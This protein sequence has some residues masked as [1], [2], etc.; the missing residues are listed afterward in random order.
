DKINRKGFFAIG[1]GTITFKQFVGVLKV[2]DLT[3]EVLP[4]IDF[5]TPDDN[6]TSIW[7]QFLIEMLQA[8]KKIE[9]KTSTLAAINLSKNTVLNLYINWF[10]Q[11]LEI[12]M[13]RGLVKKYQRISENKKSLSGKLEISKQITTN[14]IN[15]ERFYVTYN[16]YNRNNIYNAILYKCLRTIQDLGLGLA[17][18]ANVGNLLNWFPECDN[19]KVTE[20][21]F[22][23]L[24]YDRKTT[25]Y[26]TCI[27]I[28]KII[29]LNYYPNIKGGKSNVIAIMFDMNKLWEEYVLVKLQQVKV[30]E[31]SIKGQVKKDFWTSKNKKI[32]T[33]DVFVQSEKGSFIIDTKWK[34]LDET[35]TNVK[36]ADLK[37]LFVYNLYFDCQFSFLVYPNNDVEKNQIIIEKGTFCGKYEKYHCSIVKLNLIKKVDNTYTINDSIWRKLYTEIDNIQNRTRATLLPH[38]IEI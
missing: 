16:Q 28:A 10:L 27:E 26:K 17:T 33:P 22:E 7:Q 31:H 1:N 38:Q 29:L 35:N 8:T 3:I 34:V 32:I 24:V 6:N 4:K 9:V 15:L 19:I 37:Q 13:H 23:R 18:S 30:L 12:L 11:E 20:A 14:Y 5:K 2:G 21:L 36:D 25:A